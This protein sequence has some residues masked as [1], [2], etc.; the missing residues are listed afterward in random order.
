MK[1][2]IINLPERCEDCGF[3]KYVSGFNNNGPDLPDSIDCVVMGRT[4]VM[5]CYLTLKDAQFNKI[6]QKVTPAVCKWVMVRDDEN[7]EWDGK[8]PEWCPGKE[9]NLPNA[10]T[11]EKGVLD[12]Y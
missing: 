1:Q 2:V 4:I 10:I 11:I 7:K 6:T 5:E 12:A 3:R 8:A 9:M